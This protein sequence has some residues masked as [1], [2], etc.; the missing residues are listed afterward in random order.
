[1]SS[2]WLTAFMHLV[3]NLYHH[4]FKFKT[5]FLERAQT[6]DDTSDNM[7]AGPSSVLTGHHFNH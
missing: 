4:L 6:S 7:S 5:D 1:M 2:G 3:V